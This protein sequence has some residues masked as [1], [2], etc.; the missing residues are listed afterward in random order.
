MQSSAERPEENTE[1]ILLGI[2]LSEGRIL[3]DFK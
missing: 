3:G 2:Y 1:E